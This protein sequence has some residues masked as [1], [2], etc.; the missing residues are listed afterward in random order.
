VPAAAEAELK[1]YL[2]QNV[3]PR[4]RQ[5]GQHRSAFEHWFRLWNVDPALTA[6]PPDERTAARLREH[7]ADDAVR[8]AAA[9]GIRPPWLES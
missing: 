3:W 2:D 6:E 9:A 1:C 8:L 4:V 5:S 7:Y